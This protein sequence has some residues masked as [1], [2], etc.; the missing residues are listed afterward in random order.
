V[1]D[2]DLSQRRRSDRRRKVIA[3]QVL[4]DPANKGPEKTSERRTRMRK[5]ADEIFDYPEMGKRSLGPHWAQM[6]AGERERFVRLYADLLDR[7][8]FEKIDSYSGEKVRYLEAK[9]EDDQATVPT[10][11]V[12]PKGADIPV[13]YRMH[14]ADG[15]WMVHD[16]LIEGVSLVSN[17]RAQFDRI[18]RTSSAS[19]LLKRMEAQ[20]AGQASPG[21]ADKPKARGAGRE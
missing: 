21:G 11:V 4:N 1:A 13:D 16:V 10:R 5:I 17:Y 18:I 14:R 3:V 8:Y 6:P 19:E 12:T 9:I 20:A 7:A 2:G 15:R